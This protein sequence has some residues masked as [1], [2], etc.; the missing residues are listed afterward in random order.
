MTLISWWPVRGIVLAVTVLVGLLLL[1]YARRYLTILFAMV[2][3]AA[4][5]TADLLLAQNAYYGT[6]PTVRAWLEDTPADEVKEP[7]PAAPDQGMI[8]PVRIAGERSGF[9]ARPALVYLPRAWSAQ[10]RPALPVLMLLHAS[11]GMPQEWIDGAQV[12]QVAQAWAQR[13]GGVAPVLVMPDVTGEAGLGVCADTAAGNVETYL[14]GDVPAF[15]Q[16]EFG[17][18]APGAKWA[19]AGHGSGGTCAVTLALRHPDL[20]PTF[21]AFGATATVTDPQHD[22]VML[23]AGR[24]YPDSAAWL[25]DTDPPAG[26]T[27]Q[28]VG[29]ARGAGV[30]ACQVTRAGAPP[31]LATWGTQLAEALPWL[32]ARTGLVPETPEM[33]AVCAPLTG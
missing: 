19:V 22:P 8:L 13:N 7:L 21:A 32:A 24:T 2:V 26:V 4:F 16:E 12:A 20:F 1:R 27:A 18:A 10:P 11:P 17:T 31:G 23:L 29:L 25:A 9:A 5:V 30:A 15:L 33:L 3:F 14:A 6:Y 28:L